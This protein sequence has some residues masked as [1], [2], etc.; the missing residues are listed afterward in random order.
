MPTPIE[1][2]IN[3]IVGG[4]RVAKNQRLAGVID[5]L[6]FDRRCGDRRRSSAKTK[7]VAVAFLAVGNY[8]KKVNF[9]RVG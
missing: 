2:Q 8:F 6:Q 9:S 4:T 7:L 5:C 3:D 1:R